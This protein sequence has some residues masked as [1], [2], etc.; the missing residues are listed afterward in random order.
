MID[1]FLAMMAAGINSADGAGTDN[2]AMAQATPPAIVAPETVAEAVPADLA[3]IGDT[4]ATTVPTPTAPAT[5]T[6]GEGVIV[7][8]GVLL[9]GVPAT[10]TAPQAVAVPEAPAPAGMNMAVVPAGLVAE[11]QTPTGKFTTAAEVKP[12][13]NATKGSWVAVREYNGQDLLYVTH[14]WSWRCGMHAMAISVNDEPMQNWP[15]PECHMKYTTPSAILED[16]GLPYLAF[17]LG[18][19]NKIDIQIVYDDLSMDAASFDRGNILIP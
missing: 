4:L 11:P 13:M 3:P 15:L 9:E 8:N 18:S 17:R 5:V 1:F 10:T 6:M 19:V 7:G 12:I 16:D 2:T 14:I